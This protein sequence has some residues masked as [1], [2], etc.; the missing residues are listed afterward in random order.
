[1]IVKERICGEEETELLNSSV[2][3]YYQKEVEVLY[4]KHIYHTQGN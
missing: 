1:M 2:T 3:C 4:S